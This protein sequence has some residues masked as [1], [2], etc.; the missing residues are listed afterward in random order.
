M[1][2]LNAIQVTQLTKAARHASAA[3][4]TAILAAGGA[5]EVSQVLLVKW[6]TD[7]GISSRVFA[8]KNDRVN[9]PLCG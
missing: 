9:L 7:D 8:L 2:V 6:L 5:V 4:Q 1:P 3:F